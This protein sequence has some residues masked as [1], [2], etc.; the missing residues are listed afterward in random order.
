KAE[1][2]MVK[3]PKTR[4]SRSRRDPV[5][6][7][8]EPGAVSRIE[9]P[10]ARAE[11][12]AADVPN[13]EAAAEQA[14]EASQ[15]AAGDAAA[16]DATEQEALRAPQADFEPWEHEE[17]AQEAATHEGGGAESPKDE[18]AEPKPVSPQPSAQKRG[19]LALAGAGLIGGL[20]A[21]AG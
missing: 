9:E 2:S 14:A 18:Y 16:E 5:T 20:V 7:E 12:G 21:L 11:Q 8:L 17:A 15:S 10:A 1:R 3:T 13:R 4:H 19:G 6:I